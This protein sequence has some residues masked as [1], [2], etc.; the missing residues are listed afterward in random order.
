[1][2]GRFLAAGFRRVQRPCLVSLGGYGAQPLNCFQDYDAVLLA[3]MLVVDWQELTLPSVILE[4]VFY[5]NAEHLFQKMNFDL[6]KRR[7]N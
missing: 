3:T 1:L 6:A 5:K 7:Y 2:S 4:K